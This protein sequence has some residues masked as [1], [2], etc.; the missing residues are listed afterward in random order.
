MISVS[1]WKVFLTKFFLLIIKS[2]KGKY[3][4]IFGL[5]FETLGP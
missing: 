5:A 4:E 1:F 3:D 2:G